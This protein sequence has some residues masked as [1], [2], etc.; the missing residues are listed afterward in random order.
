MISVLMSIYKE[1]LE[2]IK[3]SVGSILNQTLSD[4]E[5]IVIIDNPNISDEVIDYLASVEKQDKR[6]VLLFNET[7]VG[8]AESMNKGLS[9][10]KG[11]YIARMDA[12]DVAFTDRLEKQIAFLN[13]SNADL[14]GGNCVFIDEDSEEIGK[15]ESF[16]TEIEKYLPHRNVI[17]HPTV[18]VKRSVLMN[19]GGYRNFPCSQDYDLWLRI[20]SAGYK[21]VNLPEYILY[22]RKSQRSITAN[23]RVEQ[24]YTAQYQR[25]LYRERQRQGRD[26]FSEYNYVNHINKQRLTEKKK[27]RFFSA[28]T[29]MGLFLDRVR[30]KKPSCLVPL[31]KAVVLYPTVAIEYFSYKIHTYKSKLKLI[32]K[33]VRKS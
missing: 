14:V 32:S 20:L 26:S 27:R 13:Y 9:C 22:Y 4:F 7:N 28:Q 3:A 6:L 1:K 33:I 11:D 16:R 24:F 31:M 18:L 25:K 23:K 29:D 21:L 10:A 8:L 2:W 17:I 19:V 5:F 12:D 15:N 30:K